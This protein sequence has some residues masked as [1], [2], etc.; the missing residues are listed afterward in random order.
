M[1]NSSRH[2]VVPL[3]SVPEEQRLCVKDMDEVLNVWPVQ[4]LRLRCRQDLEDPIKDRCSH[5]IWFNRGSS[6]VTLVTSHQALRLIIM[7]KNAADIA[8]IFYRTQS[9][10]L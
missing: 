9:Y 8:I 10:A 6:M 4:C 1:L 5:F 2:S 7:S 3:K